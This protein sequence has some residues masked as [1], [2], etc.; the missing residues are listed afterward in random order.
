MRLALR[1]GCRM[2]AA[3]TGYGVRSGRWWLPAMVVLLTIVA[4]AV[5]TAKV[6]A[7]TA[8]YMVF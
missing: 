3:M 5:A 1:H 8:V 6:V 4:V 7:P 2:V